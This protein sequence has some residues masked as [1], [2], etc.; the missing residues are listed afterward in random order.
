MKRGPLKYLIVI[1]TCISFLFL[2]IDFAW[3]YPTLRDTEKRIKVAFDQKMSNKVLARVY[4]EP[5]VMAMIQISPSKK[6]AMVR[7]VQGAISELEKSG[8]S[9]RVFYPIAEE[10]YNYAA[11]EILSGIVK[12]MGLG[13]LC[14]M[15]SVTNALLMLEFQWM[16][17]QA[18]QIDLQAFFKACWD[19]LGLGKE[20]ALDKKITVYNVTDVAGSKLRHLAEQIVI[21]E[22]VKK[23]DREDRINVVMYKIAEAFCREHNRYR[24]GVKQAVDKAKD[25]WRKQVA[26]KME[27]LRKAASNCDKQQ[28]AQMA[29]KR[30]YSQNPYY[31]YL[32]QHNYQ[33]AKDIEQRGIKFYKAW[34]IHSKCGKGQR[35][36]E[37]MN[38]YKALKREIERKKDAKREEKYMEGAYMGVA[39]MRGAGSTELFCDHVF[40]GPKDYAKEKI[41]QIRRELG[42]Q[43]ENLNYKKKR[44]P[45]S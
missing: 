1:S 36:Q 40:G 32:K 23:E 5:A 18:A 6:A 34:Y 2:S 26:A 4:I 7:A 29:F 38:S 8:W 33:Y 42:D 28:I 41:L 31:E 3:A 44:W 21:G 35:A 24:Y 22:G 25:G 19:G 27:Q 39:G 11:G 20:G 30:D 13:A 43:R 14:T 12:P 10:G 15:L 16:L 17:S 45:S 37:A 9:E